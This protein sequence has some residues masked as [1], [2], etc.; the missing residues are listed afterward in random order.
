MPFTVKEFIGVFRSYNISVWPFQVILI[1]SAFLIIF[2][3]FKHRNYSSKV[4]TSILIFYWFWIGLV[5]HILFFSHINPVAYGF[6]AIFILQAALFYKAGILDKKLNIIW[7][8]N[9]TSYLGAILIFYALIIYPLLGMYFGH[10][11]PENP[12]FGLPCPT[13]IFT[14][15]ILLWNKNGIPFYIIIIPVIWAVLGLSAALNLGIKEDLGLIISA[16]I[17]AAEFI[18]SKIR[19]KNIS[20]VLNNLK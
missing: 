17:F 20:T 15:G 3:A 9:P 14:F 18:R 1:I 10:I 13:T 8:N 16:I 11:Y 5:Y 6:G 4:I 12:T 2:L 19:Q 7:Q